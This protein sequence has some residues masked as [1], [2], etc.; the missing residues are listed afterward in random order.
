M[1][2]SINGQKYDVNE[3]VKCYD[4]FGEE[5]IDCV[6]FKNETEFMIVNVTS[7]PVYFTIDPVF[8]MQ[9]IP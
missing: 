9:A 6:S 4:L 7:C 2:Q 5:I 1:L 8:S 3:K